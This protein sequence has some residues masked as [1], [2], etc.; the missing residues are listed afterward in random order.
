MNWKKLLME[1]NVG[2]IDRIVR[3]LAGL[4]FAWLAFGPYDL[5]L[6]VLFGLL[7]IIGLA[8]GIFSH[9]TLYSLMGWN[10]RS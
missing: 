7:A 8:T 3:I 10:T 6:R 1:K 2:G 4:V 9:C 5:A